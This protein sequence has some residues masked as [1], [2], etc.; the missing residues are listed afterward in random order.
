MKKL[1]IVLAFC[2]GA[3]GLLACGGGS[4]DDDDTADAF[5]IDHPDGGNQPDSSG[6]GGECNPVSQTGCDANEK[7]TWIVDAA[8]DPPLG[9]TGCVTDGTVEQGGECTSPETGADNCVAGYA[10]LRGVCTEICSTSPETCG[11]GYA[12]STYM[13]FLDDLDNIGLCNQ[14]CD[15]VDQDCSDHPEDGCYL[16]GVTGVS[17]CSGIPTAAAEK[18]QGEECYGPAAGTCYLNGCA[19]GYGANLPGTTE[20]AFFCNPVDNWKDNVQGLTG[21]PDGITC[22]ATFGDRPDGPGASFH[23]RFINMLFSNTDLVPST[24]GVCLYPEDWGGSCEYFDYDQL[25]SDLGDGTV[26]EEGENYCTNHEERCM[27][28]CISIETYNAL[29]AATPIRPQW[30]RFRMTHVR[31]F[32]EQRLDDLNLNL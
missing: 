16:Q 5:V 10:C 15:P 30:E 23:C 25:V 28:D 11:D 1:A 32:W 2:C 21:D 13:Y 18:I 9:H 31:K 8:G 20:C 14:L 27:F 7:C 17:T 24:V 6:G 29:F 3:F 22:A 19:K 12:C 4:G 26:E